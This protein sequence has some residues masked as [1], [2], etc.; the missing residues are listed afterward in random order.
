MSHFGTVALIGRSNVGKSTLL[1]TALGESLAIVSPLPQTTRTSLLGIVNR[2]DD[3]IAFLDT[4]GFHHAR[5]ELGNRMNA[6]ADDTLRHADLVVYVTD[7]SCLLRPYAR[8][9][10]PTG[11]VALDPN[12]LALIAKLPENTPRLLVINKVDLVGNKHRLLPLIEAFSNRFGFAAVIPVSCLSPNDVELLVS[13]IV[14]HLPEGAARFPKDEITDRPVRYFIAE[15]VRE[16]VLL[17]TRREVP[18]AVAVTVDHCHEDD[19]LLTAAVTLHVEK[20]GQRRILVGRGGQQI[21]DIGTKARARVVQL[22]GK[23]VHLELFVKTN[24]AWKSVP[25]QLAELG[26]ENSLSEATT[27]LPKGSE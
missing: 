6:A 14:A 21:R 5:S 20:D 9:K 19:K 1:N 8:Q 10:A 16:Q 3:Q 27:A 2:G 12:D 11:G 4:P 18:H 7:V 22:V 23:K 17:A 25:R 13:T 26:Y 15:Y 24:P